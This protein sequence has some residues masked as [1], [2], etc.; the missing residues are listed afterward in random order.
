M[1]DPELVWITLHTI[2]HN[3]LSEAKTKILS[4]IPRVSAFTLIVLCPNTSR[5]PGESGAPYG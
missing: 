4:H 1:R 2:I 5:C 3:G